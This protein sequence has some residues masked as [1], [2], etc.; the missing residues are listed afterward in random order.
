V[1]SGPPRPVVILNTVGMTV[2]MAARVLQASGLA[3]EIVVDDPPDGG[4]A[5]PGRVWK[6]TPDGGALVDEGQ[7]V[8]IWARR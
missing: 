1:S 7:T 8:R 6:Q 4:K 3:V 5:A 2:D